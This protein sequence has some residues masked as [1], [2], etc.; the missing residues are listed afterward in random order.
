MKTLARHPE[1]A[2]RSLSDNGRAS[3]SA[4]ITED[5][6]GMVGL[7]VYTAVSLSLA[8]ALIHLW[9]APQHLEEWWAY[10]AFFLGTALVQGLWSLTFLRWPSSQVLCS[11][12]IWSNLAIVGMYVLTRTAGVPFGPHVGHV[13]D[14]EV[15]GMVATVAEIGIIVASAALLEETPRRRTINALLV[16]GA[17]LWA[18]RLLNL[19]PLLGIHP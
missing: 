14:P 17:G 8:A 11:F 10:G 2:A 3:S 12:G 6:G 15:L 13:E 5:G 7:A 16:I 18:A 4:L 9:A 1:L 19:F